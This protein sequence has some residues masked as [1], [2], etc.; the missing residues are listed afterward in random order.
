MRLIDADKLISY[1][2]T[3]HLNAAPTYI[4]ASQPTVAAATPQITYCA[5]CECFDAIGRD[6]GICG[7]NGEQVALTDYCSFGHE[8][9]A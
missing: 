2:D 9:E 7:R 5:D 3:N 4:I 8:K 1:C 6:T